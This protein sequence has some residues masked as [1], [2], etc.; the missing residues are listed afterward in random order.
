M[1]LCCLIESLTLLYAR[2]GKRAY[3]NFSAIPSTA[4]TRS[5]FVH[6]TLLSRDVCQLLSMGLRSGAVNVNMQSS[7][8][9]LVTRSRTV[10]H[11]VVHSGLGAQWPASLCG[12]SDD[13]SVQTASG[14]QCG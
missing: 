14:C 5:P 6:C 13:Y 10:H 9:R 8:T 12:M 11:D 4:A 3:C 2:D 1:I 7:Q